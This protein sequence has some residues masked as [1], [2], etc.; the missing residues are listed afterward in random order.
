M[1][2]RELT[3]KQKTTM[4]KDQQ[5]KDDL[6]KLY[7]LTTKILFESELI[8]FWEC[9]MQKFNFQVNNFFQSQLKTSTDLA[10]VWDSKQ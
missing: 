1:S 3:D 2:S 10:K 5:D 9:K 4:A 7:E 8:Y 6:D